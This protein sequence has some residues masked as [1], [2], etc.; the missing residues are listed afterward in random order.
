[1]KYFIIAGEASGDLHAS[2]LMQELKIAD[3]KAEFCF[4]GGDLMA[5]QGGI[6]LKHYRDMAFMGL[7]PV[8]MNLHK[9]KRNFDLAEKNL[10][11]FNP[12]VLIL[13][14]Y[15]GFNLRM[16]A[17][18]KKKN[19]KVFYYI[20]PKIWAWKTK[21]VYKIKQFV[22]EMFTIFPF[23]TEFYNQY[24]V[25]VHYV[26]NPTVD[27]LS[28]KSFSS[29]ND[30]ISRNNL[31]DQPIIA[32]LAGSRNQEISR[33]LPVMSKV[34]RRFPQFQYV[35]AGA[36]SQNIE[37]YDKVLG[38]FKIPVVFGQTYDLL[39]HST[40]ALVASGTATL[41]T[42]VLNI[43]QVV[44]YRIEAGRLGSLVKEWLVKVPFI[45]L[46]NLI[47]G[48]EVVKELFQETCTPEIV[49]NE[50]DQILNNH[51][52]RNQM[53]NGYQEMCNKLGGAGCAKR[54]ADQMINL[55]NSE[56]KRI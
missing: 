6:L 25:Q 43:P 33:I 51:K 14:D 47:T 37:K 50:L 3:P 30:F 34:T 48:R 38:D 35:I 39:K 5:A 7:I 36:P 13:V 4:F 54:A 21:R 10:L 45:S 12:D 28:K 44:C 8:L 31:P 26:G 27:E 53:L 17:F 19:I 18:A 32:L 23:E 1:M 24:G 52:Y 2:H 22:D 29:F 41:E 42:A 11:E 9:I 49:G 20:S 56:L 46:V 15:P 40:A 16:A 55:L